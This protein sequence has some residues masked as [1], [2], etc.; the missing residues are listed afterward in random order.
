MITMRINR[1]NINIEPSVMTE[2]ELTAFVSECESSIAT[3]SHQIAENNRNIKAGLLGNDA[4]WITNATEAR[5]I[6]EM[7]IAQLKTAIY[8]KRNP[9]LEY[10]DVFIS[11]AKD[12]LDPELF[13]RL[14]DEAQDRIISA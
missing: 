1:K 10:A 4:K 12:L 8:R 11:V 7:N 3:I 14:Q 5:R 9:G 13:K 6:Y 2:A